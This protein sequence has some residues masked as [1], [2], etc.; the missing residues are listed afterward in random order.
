MDAGGFAGKFAHL[1][2]VVLDAA[3]G[4]TLAHVRQALAIL[5]QACLVVKR[6]QGLG[7]GLGHPCAGMS[8]CKEKAGARGGGA[9][10]SL[11]RHVSL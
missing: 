7:G 10:P 5:V 8:R 6:R 9:R 4:P 2:M 11:C 1:H 3:R